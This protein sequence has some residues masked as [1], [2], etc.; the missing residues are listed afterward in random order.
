LAAVRHRRGT[1][2]VRTRP[3]PRVGTGTGSA[4]SNG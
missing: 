1:T 2:T 3:A 4:L